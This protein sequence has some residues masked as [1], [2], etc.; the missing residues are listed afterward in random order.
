M[1]RFAFGKN[2]IDYSKGLQYEDYLA[3]KESLQKLLPDLYGKTFLDVGCGSGL[4]S[5]AANALGAE[6]VLAFD[7][8]PD[9]ISASK[10]ILEIVS[11]WDGDIRKDSIEFKVESILNQDFKIGQFDVVYSWGVL[12]HTGDMY[13]AFDRI[14]NLV[15]EKGTLVLA[16]YNKHFTSP[17]WKLIKFTYVK[18]PRFI[19]KILVFL[20]LAIKFLGVL[21][22]SWRN[23]LKRGRGMRFYTDIV[24]WVGGYPY[25]YA[26]TD[27]VTD[28]FQSKGFKLIRL[29][30]TRGF[31]GCNEFVFEKV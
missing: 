13:A 3:A 11:Q 19:K 8:D 30:K 31:T 9:S 26:S 12:H 22:I 7:Y 21:I 5:I 4:F 24:D 15:A 6:K 23:P 17:I 20:V 25:E 18:S 28:F 27:E 29:I 14:K 2:W 1:D 16:I 10:K